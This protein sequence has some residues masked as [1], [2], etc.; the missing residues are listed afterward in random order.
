MGTGITQVAAQSGYTVYLNDISEELISKAVSRITRQLGSY[1]EKGKLTEDEKTAVLS[2]IIPSPS[3]DNA[4]NCEIVIEAATENLEIKKKI[5]SSV[6][7]VVGEGTIL[8]TNTSSISITA[9][10]AVVKNPANFIGMHFFNPVPMMK[11]VELICGICTSS[12]CKE[13]VIEFGKSLGKRVVEVKDGPG[14]MVNRMLALMSNEAAE[15]LDQGYGSVEDIDAAMM[16]GA[17]HPMGPLTLMDL[18][19]IDIMEAVMETLYTEFGDSKYRPSLLIKK[20][21]RAGMLGQKTG[22][23]F[24]VY[25]KEGKTVNPV[26]RK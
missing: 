24:Y 20:M 23:G 15:L 3:V 19:G 1:V 10:A 7:A 16:F 14:F 17:G 8:A 6:D 4:A 18:V 13:T 22:K 12:E 9:I 21:V 5:F 25:T 2:R 11:L 26:F